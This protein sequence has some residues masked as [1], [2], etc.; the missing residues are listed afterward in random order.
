MSDDNA[1]TTPADTAPAMCLWMIVLTTVML[2]GSIHVVNMILQ[3]HYPAKA[4]Y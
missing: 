2:F 3:A 1:D 4:W